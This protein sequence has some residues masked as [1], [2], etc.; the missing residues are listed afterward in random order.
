MQ[1]QRSQRPAEN[2]D[3]SWTLWD[4]A[5]GK[6]IR[7]GKH[8]EAV[9]ACVFS[10]D[11]SRFLTASYDCELCQWDA[12]TGEALGSFEGQKGRISACVYSPGGARV[13]AAIGDEATLRE[14]DAK[15]YQTLR[16]YQGHYA[17]VDTCA[18]SPD[19]T[20]IVSSAN[21]GSFRE[22][23]TRNGKE[24]RWLR[25]HNGRIRAC[26]YATDSLIVSASADSTLRFWSSASGQCLYT[27]YG[28][29]AFGCMAIL[30]TQLVA[31][32][33]LDNVWL[34]DFEALVGAAKR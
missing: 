6:A 9:S 7:S 26:A 3:G 17:W 20:R 33:G 12:R 29:A 19:G 22:W 21:D 28:A 27:I 11:S 2:A 5:T 14:W 15:N 10:P 31:A 24:L 4:R 23:D 8:A 32:D 16:V 18:Y 25:G 30:G 34:L 13:L 1:I